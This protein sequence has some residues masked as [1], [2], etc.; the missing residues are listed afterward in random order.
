MNRLLITGSRDWSDEMTLVDQIN[1]AVDLLDIQV[2]VHGDCPIGAD[3]MADRAAKRL[4]LLVYKYPADWNA[5]RKAGLGPGPTRNQYMVDGGAELCLAFPMP[6]S[7]GTWD[8]VR[9]CHTAGIPTLVTHP[10]KTTQRK[11]GQ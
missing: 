3:P 6:T 5:I 2:L 8:T 10:R 9:R 11:A 4:G 1:W 7:K